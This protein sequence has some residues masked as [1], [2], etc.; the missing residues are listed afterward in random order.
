[1]T[2]LVLNLVCSTED[3]GARST[4]RFVH[5]YSVIKHDSRR[6]GVIYIGGKFMTAHIIFMVA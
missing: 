3:F 1:M 4:E 2:I 5:S 6:D